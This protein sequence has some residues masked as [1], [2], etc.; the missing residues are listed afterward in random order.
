MII[1]ISAVSSTGKTLMAQKLLEKYHIT[2]LSID[3]LKMGLYRGDKNCGFTPL[4]SNEVIGDKLWPIVKG[5][6]MTNIENE[7]H[8]IIEG[9][10][11]L[12]H[13][14]K[15]FD[16]F[17]SEK[18]IPVFFGFSTNYI[19]E[20]FET[21]I[22]EH[23]NAIEHRAGSEERTVNEVINEHT[24]FK[25]ACINAD[26]RYFEIENDYDTEI[27][28]IYDYIETEKRRINCLK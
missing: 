23:R 15:D 25:E 24:E 11:I 1:L 20:N 17:Y 28:K 6:I 26:V 12:P 16:N 21:K 13:Y 5:I 27:M 19:Q 22:V 18:I 4:D 8:L 14:L 2:Y 9:C 3:H 7:Q 10:Y